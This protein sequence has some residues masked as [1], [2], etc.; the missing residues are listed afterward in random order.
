MIKTIRL[1]IFNLVTGAESDDDWE[2]P[3]V[4]APNK[5]ATRESQ[6]P[7]VVNTF[8]I[9]Q[10]HGLFHVHKQKHEFICKVQV[11]ILFID[12]TMEINLI[13]SDY[14]LPVYDDKCQA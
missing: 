11:V 5:S 7:Y 1:C 2:Y 4:Q 9:N 6:Y 8:H 14:L 12:K 10:K 3:P 13:Y